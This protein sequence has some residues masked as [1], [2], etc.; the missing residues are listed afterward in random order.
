V[1]VAVEVEQAL[2]LLVLVVQVAVEQ[3]HILP[4]QIQLLEP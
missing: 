2:E 3:A 4:F 1:V